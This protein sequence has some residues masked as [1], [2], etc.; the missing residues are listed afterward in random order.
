LTP[1]PWYPILRGT[2]QQALFEV[3]RAKGYAC[4]YR[5]LRIAD[6][7]A[8]QGIWLVS[9]MTLAARVHTLDGRRL[10]RP[11]LAA[12]FTELVDAAIV[13]DR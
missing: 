1:P 9:S 2:T 5:A 7:L 10:P 11:P 13:S 4:D 6:L 12:E 8:A 3:A